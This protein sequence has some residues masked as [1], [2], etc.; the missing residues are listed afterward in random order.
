MLINE[1][2]ANSEAPRTDFIEL[3]NRSNLEVE[4]SGCSLSDDPLTNKFVLPPNTRIPPRGFL[5]V[6]QEQLGFGLDSGGETVFLRNSAG[7]R[8]LDAVRFGPQAVNVAS[9]RHRDGAREWYPLAEPTPGGPNA[10]I[11]VHDIVINEIMYKPISTLEDDQYVELYNQGTNAVD[12][13]GW[14]FTAGIDYEFPTGT[15]LV[16]DGYLVVAKNALRLQT[17]YPGLTPRNTQGNFKGRLG[18]KSDRVALTR[19]DSNVTTNGLGQVGTNTV[20]VVVDEVQDITNIQLKCIL[21]SLI[22]PSHFILTGDSN[23]IV[24]PNFFSWSK[25]KTYFYQSGDA[26]SQTS[27]RE[28]TQYLPRQRMCL[29]VRLQHAQRM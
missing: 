22:H 13:G 14:R 23:Q 3:H 25:V 27:P 6:G 1:F 16:A 7:T 12:L 4:L 5:A 17:N 15:V 18:K 11:Q 28:A 9:G 19:P 21:Q 2:L 24:H 29:Q 20:Y 8:V 26:G 10:R